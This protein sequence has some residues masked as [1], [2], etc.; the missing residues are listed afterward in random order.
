V[1]RITAN[2][3]HYRFFDQR[4]WDKFVE[5]RSSINSVTAVRLGC[6]FIDLRGPDPRAPVDAIFHA[7]T[8]GLTGIWRT[9]REP[10][11]P[12]AAHGA[13]RTGIKF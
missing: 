3:T 12:S 8:G 10:E 5:K 1:T 4:E 11:F 9:G 2:L 7:P 6:R 13:L